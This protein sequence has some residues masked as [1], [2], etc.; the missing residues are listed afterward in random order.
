MAFK[1]KGS[2]AERELLTMLWGVNFAAIRAAGSGVQKFYSPDV[3]ASNGSKIMAIECKSTKHKYQYFD[4]EQV[5]QLLAFATMF[6]AE[7]WLAVKFSADWKFFKPSDLK[8]TGKA[9][10]VT[11]ENDSKLFS[12]ICKITTETG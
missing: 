10:V 2:A 4:P 11:N 1:A 12:D 6:K 8:Q 3:L 9:F 7:P 5:R